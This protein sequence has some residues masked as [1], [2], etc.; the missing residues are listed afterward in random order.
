[1]TKHVDFSLQFRPG[2]NLPRRFLLSALALVLLVVLPVGTEAKDAE[3]A[4][5][6]PLFNRL[7]NYEIQRYDERE[8]DSY[9]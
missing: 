3:G 1:M 9:D 4:K 6:H 8:F 5:D 2:G 7:P